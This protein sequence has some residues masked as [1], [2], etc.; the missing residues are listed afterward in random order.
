[1]DEETRL[2]CER[3]ALKKGKQK[4]LVEE[5]QPIKR[6][7]TEIS[8]PLEKAWYLSFA[9][10][11]PVTTESKNDDYLEEYGPKTWQD[12]YGFAQSVIFVNGPR[13]QFRSQK[14]CHVLDSLHDYVSKW[15]TQKL[16]LML[17]G[18]TGTGKTRCLSLL[19]KLL[20]LECV[21][22]HE[23]FV[24]ELSREEIKERLAAFGSR[25]LNCLPKLWVVEHY[26]TLNEGIKTLLNNSLPGMM[27]TG[28]VVCTSWPSTTQ[29]SSKF[30]HHEF[31]PW[32]IASKKLFLEESWMPGFLSQP[33]VMQRLL[34]EGGESVSKTLCL[35][36]LWKTFAFAQ[37]GE[38]E[39]DSF[40]PVNL[41]SLMEESFS[42]RWCPARSL[43]LE[44]G[45][46]ELTSQLLQEMVPMALAQGRCRNDV[47]FM[48]KSLDYFS[49]MDSTVGYSS[50]AYKCIMESR[51]IQSQVRKNASSSLEKFNSGSLLP[52]PQN[53]IFKSKVTSTEKS[54]RQLIHQCRGS[55][56]TRAYAEDLQLFLQASKKPWKSPFSIK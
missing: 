13:N 31:L 51:L 54:A 25:G 56:D 28:A 24:D 8:V 47:D 34:K 21:F 16:P 30:I 32:S 37:Q 43:A 6:F 55:S 18:E 17:T 29:P 14:F 19:G 35:A 2:L 46:T 48:A 42:E 5:P 9:E 22:L 44:A 4:S 40:V 49:S 33:K 26:D 7:K 1:M 38:L 11:K 27:K 50:S 3:R 45:E 52:I 41:R 10:E 15:K 23:I 36:Q 39:E 53:F 20:G 12:I